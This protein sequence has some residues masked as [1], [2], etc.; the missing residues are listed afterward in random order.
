MN[1]PWDIELRPDQ[2]RRPWVA[3]RW[4]QLPEAVP[5][6]TDAMLARHFKTGAYKLQT[7]D[8]VRPTDEMVQRLIHYATTAPF[9]P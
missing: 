5:T 9:D 6:P 2:R 3:T 1:V 8:E 7:W 4:L